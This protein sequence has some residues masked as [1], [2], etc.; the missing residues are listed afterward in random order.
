[1]LIHAPNYLFLVP[2]GFMFII[3][4][5]FLTLLAFGPVLIGGFFLDIHP[6]VLSSLL[7]ILGYQVLF[8]GIFAKTYA[9]VHLGQLDWLVDLITRA[10]TIEKAS[11]I[12]L[13]LF[14]IGFLINLF[15]LARWVKTGF[16][17]LS[18]L[19]TAIFGS[20]IIILGIQTIFSSFLL[21][22]L[23]LKKTLD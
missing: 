5:F 17:P 10:L 20:T 4:M 14:L 16:G 18:E 19:R 7:S 21:S 1:M 12:G 15:I 22:I 13:L 11:T 6:M 9:A 23:S 3:G 2:G 8:L